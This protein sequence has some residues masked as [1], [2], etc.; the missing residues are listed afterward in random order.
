M[1]RIRLI[2]LYAVIHI[3]ILLALS[4]ISYGIGVTPSTLTMPF[5]SGNTKTV[6]FMAENNGINDADVKI[7][8]TGELKDFI[9][10]EEKGVIPA[11]GKK[12][13]TFTIKYPE[14]LSP[15]THSGKLVIEEIAT[16]EQFL[17]GGSGFGAKGAVIMQLNVKVPYNGKYM[18]LKF[19]PM[20][21]VVS[22]ES[23]FFTLNAN[24]Y[25]SEDI[26]D[27]SG[28]IKIMDAGSNEIDTID[29]TMIHEIIKPMESGEFRGIW[30]VPEEENEDDAMAGEYYLNAMVDYGGEK[31]ATASYPLRIG[32]E[33][34]EIIDVAT[35]NINA[36]NVGKFVIKVQSKWNKQ[37][38]NVYADI[39]IMHDG[40]EVGE[41]KTSSVDVYGFATG[42]L[43]GYW[44]IGDM[45]YEEYSARIVV[46]Y[47]DSSVEK[48]VT[49]GP[50][51]EAEFE[52]PVFFS[53]MNIIL[54][55]VL[56]LVIILSV[57]GLFFLMKKTPVSVKKAGKR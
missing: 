48:A 38:S 46:H 19:P 10:L 4:G 9:E 14:E 18:E 1:K 27:A 6:E 43:T 54:I 49:F 21:S 40:E 32:K 31:P 3:V 34:I 25:G 16:A 53:N 56:I 35:S 57:I 22:G 44:E 28:I 30:S 42:S 39:I 15:G 29:L 45:I 37:L 52:K 36:N 20:R 7:F 41:I 55:S 5:E 26:T 23:I 13:F 11:K 8:V 50:G 51:K 17:E 47:G 24:N 33:S 12:K 2:F